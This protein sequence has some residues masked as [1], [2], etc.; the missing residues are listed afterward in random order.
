MIKQ[1]TLENPVKTAYLGIG[2]NLGNKKI[3]IEKAKF[4]LENY[5]I[6]IQNLSSFYE[7]LSWPNF[8]LPK[9]LNIVLK[10]KTLLNPIE[11]L[12]TIKNIEKKLGRTVTKKNYPR[13]CDIDIIDYD[14][15][16]LNL[17]NNKDVVQIPHPRFESRNFVLMPLFEINKNWSHPKN[18]IKI[19]YLIE[20]LDYKSLRSIKLI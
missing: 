17:K 10:I 7:T 14:N 16:V 9:Y 11:L 12:S 18:K 8:N 20:K 13:T 5:S 3:N 19:N 1:D 2:S 6:K 15:K 4:F